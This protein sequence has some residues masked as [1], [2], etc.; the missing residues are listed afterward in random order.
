MDA[1]SLWHVVVGL[2][3]ILGMGVSFLL[4]VDQWWAERKERMQ[5]SEWRS[6]RMPDEQ[7]HR[8]VKALNELHERHVI[9]A[10]FQR[11]GNGR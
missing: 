2:S 10:D 7:I 8:R 6:E 11:R 9:R 5:A 4:I 1:L 3:I